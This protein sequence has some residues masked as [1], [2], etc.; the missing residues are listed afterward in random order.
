MLLRRRRV[1]RALSV[2]ILLCG[3][4]LASPSSPADEIQFQDF[5][6]RILFESTFAGNTGRILA[7]SGCETEMACEVTISAPSTGA[8]VLSNALLALPDGTTGV[9]VS[10]PDGFLTNDEGQR[11][12]ARAAYT[13]NLGS[14][15]SEAFGSATCAPIPG[16]CDYTLDTIRFRSD[17]KA[18][19]VETRRSEPSCFAVQVGAYEDRAE[20]TVML[21]RLMQAFPDPMT[22]SQVV[23]RDKTRW[24]LR[25]LA[26]SRLEALKVSGR[27]LGEQGIK[28]WI[29]P[30][31]C[32]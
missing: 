21:N 1:T 19:T 18:A 4:M 31:P 24:R 11:I 9:N 3:F 16:G 14:D 8:T 13:V 29:V 7:I 2:T 12:N 27:L 32:T 20:A 26:T 30:I 6:D 22:L 5:S 23:T 10:D 15:V 28:A 25:V 17:V